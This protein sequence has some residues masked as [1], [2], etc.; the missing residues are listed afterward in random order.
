MNKK[1]LKKYMYSL[2]KMHTLTK[3]SNFH[4]LM[5]T[6]IVIFILG[7]ADNV[8]TNMSVSFQG[9][10]RLIFF[11]I[12]VLFFLVID[13]IS[14]KKYSQSRLAGLIEVIAVYADMIMLTELCGDG[15][16]LSLQTIIIAVFIM[17]IYFICW[18]LIVIWYESNEIAGK[19]RKFLKNIYY[20]MVLIGLIIM[21]IYIISEKIIFFLLSVLII[22]CQMGSYIFCYVL[23]LKFPFKRKLEK[24]FGPK[25]IE[26]N[27]IF[28]NKKKNKEK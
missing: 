9:K 28:I 17:F 18:S 16:G 23:I 1:G 8:M 4:C 20:G 6:M 12:I 2:S 13:R 25:D 3:T 5:G 14:W 10:R 24:E 26:A 27:S 22:G 21:M 15:F 11:F 19:D 7:L